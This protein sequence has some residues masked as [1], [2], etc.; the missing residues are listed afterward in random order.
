MHSLK[1]FSLKKVMATPVPDEFLCPITLLLM[2][3][4]VIGSDGQTYERS[5]IMQW[6]RTNRQSPLTRQPMTLDSLKPNYALKSAIARYKT[7]VLPKKKLAPAASASTSVAAPAPAPAP[8]MVPAL[9]R[10]PVASAPPADDVYYAI[11]VYQQ[12]MNQQQYNQPFINRQQTSVAIDTP[13]VRRKKML[14]ACL[15]VTMFVVFIIIVVRI[16][17]S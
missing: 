12:D 4:P 7:Q 11:Q 3:D 10:Q 5:A 15:C 1:I 6:L 9:I 16:L 14:I 2:N 8:V 17:E 13:E